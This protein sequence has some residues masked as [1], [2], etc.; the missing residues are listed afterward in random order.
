MITKTAIDDLSERT[1]AIFLRE[2][3]RGFIEPG[4]ISLA[5]RLVLNEC[6]INFL[7]QLKIDMNQRI[8]IPLWKSYSTRSQVLRR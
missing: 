1:Y 5:H 6:T 8:N 3:K 2:S 7:S 4:S